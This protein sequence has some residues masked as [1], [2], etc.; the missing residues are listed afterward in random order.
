MNHDGYISPVTGK[1]FGHCIAVANVAIKMDI[2]LDGAFQ[3]LAIPGRARV[4][5]EEGAPHIIIDSRNLET[6]VGEEAHRFAAD[7]S[8]CA[9]NDCHAHLWPTIK[10]VDLPS[11]VARNSSQG[12]NRTAR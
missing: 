3:F 4:R 11:R 2:A 5:A 1:D 10:R 8:C 12:G 7:Q 9:R 6:L